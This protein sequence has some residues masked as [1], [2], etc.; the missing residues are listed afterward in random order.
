VIIPY[1]QLAS[2]SS[3]NRLAYLK[4]VR[5]I[6]QVHISRAMYSLEVQVETRGE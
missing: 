6:V 2:T 1:E 5:I 4:R 3:Y